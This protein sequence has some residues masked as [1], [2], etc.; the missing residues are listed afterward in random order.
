MIANLQILDLNMQQ[1]IGQTNVQ[2]KPG[3]NVVVG[4]NGCGKSSLFEVLTTM[5]NPILEQS[6]Y[7]KLI[8]DPS[9]KVH[10]YS[11]EHA[12]KSMTDRQGTAFE[13]SKD[14]HGQALRKLL[15][16]IDNLESEAIIILDEPETALDFNAVWELC[17]TIT[18]K[19]NIQF[20]ISTHH[21]LFFT[22]DKANFINLDRDDKNY[23]QS[24]LK[25]LSKR[26]K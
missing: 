6:N 5:T 14:S 12:T 10:T 25:K 22:M 7:A 21:P 16:V 26:L 2:F 4:S 23:V 20:I 19:K 11:A 17:K 8:W 9:V 18:A 3:I 24:I 13:S 1:R 15:S